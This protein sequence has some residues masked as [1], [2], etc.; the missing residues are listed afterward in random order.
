MFVFRFRRL[1]VSSVSR[2]GGG[3]EFFL[4]DLI[5]EIDRIGDKL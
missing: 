5:H 4:V 2:V 3:L 1:S